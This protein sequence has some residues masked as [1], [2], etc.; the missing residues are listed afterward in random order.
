[1]PSLPE[2][3]EPGGSQSAWEAHGG[4]ETGPVV[5][6]PGDPDIVYANCKGRFGLYNRRTGQEAQYYVGF[7][8]LYGHNPRDLDFRFQRVVPIHVSPHDPNKVYHGSQYVHMTTNGGQLWETISPD[9][10]AFTPETQVIS[11]T[12]ITID[13]TGEEHFS[14]LYDIQESVL[15]PGVIWTGANDGPVH[16]TRDGGRNWDDVTPPGIGPYGRVQ[17]IAVSHH[18]PAKAYVAILR[19]MMGD[20]TPHTYRTNDYGATWTRITTGDNG[21]PNHHPVRVRARG[22]RPRGPALPGHR[23]RDVRLV[24]RLRL[25]AA[26]PAEPSGDAHHGHEGGAGGSGVVD[27]GV[28]DSGFWITSRHCTN[29]ATV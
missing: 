24:R 5:P 13:V 20:F 18:D 12:P 8:N 15:E 16:V 27:N 17:T 26:L 6:K 3:S 9:L 23:V 28:G 1:M 11:G 7:G 10:T 14:V 29:S 2:R 22:S 25:L 4:C 21:V 19:Y